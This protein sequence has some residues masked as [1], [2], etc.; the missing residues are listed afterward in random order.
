MTPSGKNAIVTAL[1]AVLGLT[2]I[3]MVGIA[4]FATVGSHRDQ[5]RKLMEAVAE[6]GTHRIVDYLEPVWVIHDLPDQV[7]NAGLNSPGA[8]EDLTH[9]LFEQL[10]RRPNLAGIHYGSRRG[11]FVYVSREVPDTAAPYLSK[12][13][14]AS[15]GLRTAEVILRDESFR[16]V[17][18]RL[19][20]DDRFDPRNRPWY[21]AI[22]HSDHETWTLPYRF[23]T[24]ERPGV[25]VAVPVKDLDG[26]TAGVISVDLE[27]GRVSEFLDDVRIAP[28]GVAFIVDASGHVIAT[29]DSNRRGAARDRVTS[30]AAAAFDASVMAGALRASGRASL[31][32]VPHGDPS[33]ARFSVDGRS[34]FGSFLR[35]P[36]QPVPWIIGVYAPEASFHQ[37]RDRAELILLVSAGFIALVACCAGVWLGRGVDR[38]LKQ[39]N[40][41]VLQR[42]SEDRFEKLSEAVPMPV[43]LTE[44]ETGKVV[45][46]NQRARE[47]FGVLGDLSRVTATDFYADPDDRARLRA[48]LLRDGGVDQFELMMQRADGARFWALLS[49]RTFEYRDRTHLLTGI[50]DISARKAAE[51]V[52]ANAAYRDSLTNLPNRVELRKR[53]AEAEVAGIGRSTL[54]VLVV[55]QLRQVDDYMGQRHGDLLLTTVAQRLLRVVEPEPSPGRLAARLIGGEFAVWLPDVST[56]AAAAEIAERIAAEFAEPV[57]LD[58][59]AFRVSVSIGLAF[60]WVTGSAPD[61]LTRAARAALDIARE[62]RSGRIER[63]DHERHRQHQRRQ[64]LM[65]AMPTAIERREIAPL[66]QPIVRLH[67]RHVVGF[68]ALARWSHPD[69][70]T[71]SPDLFIPLAEETGLILPLGRVQLERA[72]ELLQTWRASRRIAELPSIAVNLSPR[73]V[74]DPV[75]VGRFTEYLRDL[76]PIA[77]A[78]KLEVTESAIIGDLEVFAE[79]LESLRAYGVRLCLDDFGTGYSSLSHL[80]RFRF[81]VLKVDRS[82][83]SRMTV[84]GEADRLVR[85]IIDLAHDF[86]MEVVAEGIEHEAEA[87]RLHRYGCECGQGYLFSPAVSADRASAMIAET[88][89]T[90]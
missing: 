41:A 26:E 15:Q 62:S 43:T 18:R 5:A 6:Q 14:I 4:H 68:E 53:L 40:A 57:G 29:P 34:Y 90:H 66:F 79:V 38:S 56:E 71:I 8:E 21:V 61:A 73:Q 39:I 63:F 89:P 78:L 88:M 47:T 33:F 83:V 54:L 37:D 60:S 48:S 2:I 7:A 25:T 87:E 30:G 31:A 13:V 44:I 9:F 16:E 80:H 12:V 24:S 49:A 77:S 84:A 17:S 28:G 59:S 10:R 74:M 52:L 67:D 51:A 86:G 85:S 32:D 45:F 20:P 55:D 76:G 58:E 35:F 81:D 50:N 82:F 11:D 1:V 27:I 46:A 36:A 75:W 42:E 22:E 72:V 19:D 3:C 64:T 70:G 69:L 65:E 23:Y